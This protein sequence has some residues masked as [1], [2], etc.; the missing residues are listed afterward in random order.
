MYSSATAVKYV[1]MMWMRFVCQDENVYVINIKHEH[2]K[3]TCALNKVRRERR[4]KSMLS[5]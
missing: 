1:N 5:P 4:C 3:K 2:R